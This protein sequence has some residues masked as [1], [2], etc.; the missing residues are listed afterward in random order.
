MTHLNW[1]IAFSFVVG[2]DVAIDSWVNDYRV[3]CWKDNVSSLV[4]TVENHPS[5]TVRVVLSYSQGNQSLLSLRSCPYLMWK[6][7]ERRVNWCYPYL[8]THN[9]CRLNELSF[10]SFHV[11]ISQMLKV[12]GMEWVRTYS[13]DASKGCRSTCLVLT[14]ELGCTW[15]LRSKLVLSRDHPQNT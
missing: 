1:Y 9:R 3:S 4:P 8:V 10:V 7:P 15:W 13:L 12:L 11:A 6:V 14:L 2:F 5:P